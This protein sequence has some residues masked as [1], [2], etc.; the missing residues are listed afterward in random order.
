M[1]GGIAGGSTGRVAAGA[2][3]AQRGAPIG[4]CSQPRWCDDLRR[5]VSLPIHCYSEFT[6]KVIGRLRHGS[7]VV[8]LLL[9]AVLFVAPTVDCGLFD[10]EGHPHSSATL[11]AGHVTLPVGEDHHAHGADGH[12]H[13]TNDG[14]VECCGQHAFHCIFQSVLPSGTRNAPPLHLLALFLAVSV[15]AATA[16]GFSAG[17]MRAPP[18]SSSLAVGGREVLTRFCIA[19]R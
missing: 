17:G 5:A 3:A 12:S 13:G 2:P 10:G 1:S 4:G 18:R 8:A 9:A 7:S 19:R 16:L 6:V 14:F 11:F 15:I